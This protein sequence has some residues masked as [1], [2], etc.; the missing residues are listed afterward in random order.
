[1]IKLEHQDS[2]K[3]QEIEEEWLSVSILGDWQHLGDLGDRGPS[4]LAV[5]IVEAQGSSCTRFELHRAGDG[6]RR[7]LVSTHC[8][9]DMGGD[10]TPCALVGVTTWIRGDCQ[11]TDTTG[12]IPLAFFTFKHLLPSITSSIYFMSLAMISISC[13]LVLL[14]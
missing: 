8:L 10:I 6:K 12:K 1:M 7:L 14:A 11:I 3:G 2:S 13:M 4:E 5:E 9:C